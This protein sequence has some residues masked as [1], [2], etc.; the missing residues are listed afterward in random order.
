MISKSEF[1]NK[2][3]SAEEKSIKANIEVMSCKAGSKAK[4][5]KCGSRFLK[6]SK[7]AI[8]LKQRECAVKFKLAQYDRDAEIACQNNE[9]EALRAKEEIELEF[10]RK[11]KELQRAAAERKKVIQRNLVIKQKELEMQRAAEEMKGWDEASSMITIDQLHEPISGME[12]SPEIEFSQPPKEVWEVRSNARSESNCEMRNEV[13]NWRESN[14]YNRGEFSD[15]YQPL[16]PVKSVTKLTPTEETHKIMSPPLPQ[17][18]TASAPMPCYPTGMDYPLPRPV[19]P[20]CKDDP[21]KYLSFTKTFKTHIGARG[22][23]N[24]ACLTYLIQ[25]CSDKVRRRIEHFQ[26][27]PDG[28][29]RAWH[30]LYLNYGQPYIVANCYERELLAFPRITPEDREGLADYAI[31]LENSLNALEELGEFASMNSLNTLKDILGKLPSK[32]RHYWS[33]K[34]FE[35]RERTGREAGFH[36]LVEF[37]VYKAEVKNSMYGRMDC[38]NR[39]NTTERRRVT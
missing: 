15:P 17:F 39:I 22:L 8:S 36:E 1:F 38:S 19:I 16:P 26:S 21:T 27:K 10:E 34:A 33:Q 35:V 6:S 12:R 5:S 31:L 25:H 20:K 14:P 2:S 32:F 3:L 13:K 30:A 7:S 23:S 29:S 24:D 37:V 9:S 11:A 4:S 18:Q 28:F